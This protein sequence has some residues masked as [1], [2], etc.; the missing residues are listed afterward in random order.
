MKVFFLA[1]GSPFEKPFNSFTVLFP[2]LDVRWLCLQYELLFD[3]LSPNF[4]MQFNNSVLSLRT[5]LVGQVWIDIFGFS[6]LPL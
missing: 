5:F 3:F 4:F 1:V 2:P 6:L